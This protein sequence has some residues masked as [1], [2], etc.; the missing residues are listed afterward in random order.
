M[1][2]FP[3]IITKKKAICASPADKLARGHNAA[4]FTIILI[5][6]TFFARIFIAAFTGLGIGESYYFR[7]VLHL[8]LSYFDQPPLFFW[9]SWLSTKV[10]G[11]TNLGLRFPAVALF[12]GT[13][14]LLFLITKKL[15][16]AKAGFWAV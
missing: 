10:F 5:G 9:L 4:Y 8:S 16:S 13:S 6:I 12:A 15:F 7:G 3:E 14:W 1:L 2:D 11:L